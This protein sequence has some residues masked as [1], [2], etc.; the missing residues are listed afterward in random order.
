MGQ[1]YRANDDQTSKYLRDKVRHREITE[2]EDFYDEAP[3]K[4]KIKRKK[5]K[6]SEKQ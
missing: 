1:T 2:W 4:E 5:P 6:R 3:R